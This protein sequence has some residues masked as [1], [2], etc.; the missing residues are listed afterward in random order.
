MNQFPTFKTWTPP[1]GGIAFVSQDLDKG[2][3]L[4]YAGSYCPVCFPVS[5]DVVIL[6]MES[7]PDVKEQIAIKWDVFLGQIADSAESGCQFCGFMAARFFHDQM[8][9]IDFGISVESPVTGCCG[10]APKGELTEDVKEAIEHLRHHAGDDN[11]ITLIVESFER[12]RSASRLGKIRLSAGF[13]NLPNGDVRQILGVRSEI[14]LEL[15]TH[16]GR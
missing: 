10:S 13:T 9:T 12:G 5:R 11:S 14:I 8:L 16:K 7:S 6:F 15:Y 2:K 3:E 1:A 4:R